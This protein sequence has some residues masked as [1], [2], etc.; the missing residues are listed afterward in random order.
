MS[1]DEGLGAPKR[2][3]RRLAE[4]DHTAAGEAYTTAA[5]EGLA[6]HGSATHPAYE[7]RDRS[8][9]G[10]SLT[11]FA[12]AAVCHRV[13]G[14]SDR[15][16]K[17]SREGIAVAEELRDHVLTNG[18]ERAACDEFVG[19]LLS[20][21]GDE[22]NSEAYGRAKEAYGTADPEDPASE[23]GR[24]FLQAGTELIAHLSRPDDV[25]WDEVHGSGGDDALNRRVRTKRARVESFA[26]ERV[27]ESKL[28]A[29][30]G[31]TEY[32]TGRYGCP[33]CGS[34]DVNYIAGTTLCLRC[35]AYTERV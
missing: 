5:R 9:A 29:P 15:G 31:S 10:R 4:E 22:G 23:T 1:E 13:A 27:R 16:E 14:E 8:A 28:H 19:D 24:P 11:C 17:V 2:A 21:V 20:V 12:R 33:D 25:G 32:N 3:V 34:D 6:G 30:R 26:E 18:V 7:R 35:S